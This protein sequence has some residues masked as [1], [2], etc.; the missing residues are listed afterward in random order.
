M[1]RQLDGAI[2]IYMYFGDEN[3]VQIE[4]VDEKSG[5]HFLKADMD[6]RDFT[7]M[8]VGNCAEMPCKFSLSTEN[9]GKRYEHKTELV[10]VPS[11]W[12][13]TKL[14]ARQALELFEVD[15]W[16]ARGGD[17][18]NH[19]RIKKTDGGYTT[20]EVAFYRFVEEEQ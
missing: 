18:G 13:D 3:R 15:G 17:I 1:N 12:R 9:V 7:R 20:Y 8:I 6:S 4:F 11:N 5:T 14:L 2:S 19:H 16:I 10:T